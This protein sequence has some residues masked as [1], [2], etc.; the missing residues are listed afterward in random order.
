MR[1]LEPGRQGERATPGLDS[2]GGS[3]KAGAC[4]VGAIA[5]KK[6]APASRQTT[7]LLC[8]MWCLLQALARR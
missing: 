3:C 8:T 5:E 1:P 7:V 2:G 4:P 6:E